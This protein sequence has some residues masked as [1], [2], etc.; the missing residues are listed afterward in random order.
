[1]WSRTRS[2][3]ILRPDF[4][5]FNLYPHSRLHVY[6]SV[7]VFVRNILFLYVLM[8]VLISFLLIR[9]CYIACSPE[10]GTQWDQE[11]YDSDK[12]NRLWEKWQ[13]GFKHIPI[14]KPW[15]TANG[16]KKLC[17][18]PRLKPR[19][20]S[21]EEEWTRRNGRVW[22]RAEQSRRKMTAPVNLWGVF[23]PVN[24]TRWWK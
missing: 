1:M 5:M 9:G 11:T 21:K 10:V 7:M 3:L 4:L 18:K 12:E 2:S 17:P 22:I 24:G 15:P 6:I 16:T 14:E 8:E 23:S 20:T 13:R 19:P